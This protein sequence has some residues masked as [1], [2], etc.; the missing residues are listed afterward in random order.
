MSD[1]GLI[2]GHIQD[3]ASSVDGVA[4]AL[5][6]APPPSPIVVNVPELASTPIVVNVALPEL[7]PAAVT[8][9]VPQAAAPEVNVSAPNVAIQSDVHVPPVVPNAY[10]VRITE[11]D[12]NG[13][14]AAFII[15]P[16]GA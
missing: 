4:Q 5:K 7:P 1:A 2:A 11:R 10:E 8:V 6:D 16:I 14:I 13:F 15:S 12:P 9:N 3:L